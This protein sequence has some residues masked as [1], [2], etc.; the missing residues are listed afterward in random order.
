MSKKQSCSIVVEEGAVYCRYMRA[1]LID[2][3]F[4]VVG[5]EDAGGRRTR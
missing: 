5:P 2:Q 1:E 4:C 3:S